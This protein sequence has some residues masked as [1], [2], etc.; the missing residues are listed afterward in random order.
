MNRCWNVL[1]LLCDSA[2]LPA[3]IRPGF[4]RIVMN[5]PLSPAPFL[6]QAFSLVRPG[7]RIHLYALQSRDGEALPLLEGRGA[8]EVREH[9][10]HTYSPSQWLAV[11]DIHVGEPSPSLVRGG[12]DR[13]KTGS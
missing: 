11:Y 9:V 13:K 4:D 3:F 10:V 12:A 7:G 1:P 6:G 8:T 2:R 5:L